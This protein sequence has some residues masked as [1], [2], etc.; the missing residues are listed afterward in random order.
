[1]RSPWA[2]PLLLALLL[3]GACGR[4]PGPV[5]D[6]SHRLWQQR[7]APLRD[8]DQWHLRGRVALFIDE[9]VYNLGLDWIHGRNDNSLT[10]E[11]AL[12]QGMV[13][14]RRLDDVYQLSTADGEVRRADSAE[15]LLRQVTGWDIPVEGLEYWVRG[16]PA[17]DTPARPDIDTFGRL[18][19]LQ[20]DGW[21]IH[22]LDYDD[23]GDALPVLPRRL[24]MKRGP[25]RI[26]IVI[27]Q[28]QKAPARPRDNLFPDFPD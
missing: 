11:A 26:K 15:R 27:D 7:Q 10:L 22:Y 23:P 18:Q 19:I 12:G 2:L 3:T 1:M 9:E 20:Q 17:P 24:Y 25:V 16:L 28:W 6:Q 8:F 13:R 4:I 21:W 5:T 14:I